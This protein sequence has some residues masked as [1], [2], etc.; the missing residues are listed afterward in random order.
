[1]RSRAAALFDGAVC[2]RTWQYCLSTGRFFDRTLRVRRTDGGTDLAHDSESVAV[3]ADGVSG[4]ASYRPL[5]EIFGDALIGAFDDLDLAAPAAAARAAGGAPRVDGTTATAAG[6]E[7][8][9][10]SNVD[11]RLQVR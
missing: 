1:M 11:L 3:A 8:T 2:V 9:T 5:H 4:A 7:Q 10:T 6:A